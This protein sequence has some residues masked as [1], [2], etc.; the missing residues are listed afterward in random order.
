[1]NRGNNFYFLEVEGELPIH[2]T[3]LELH[4]INQTANE[5]SVSAA[6]LCW[7]P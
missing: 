1:M 5:F 3:S 4:T 6:V 7:V 2:F